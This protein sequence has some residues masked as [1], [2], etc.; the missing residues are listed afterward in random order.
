[1]FGG[2]EADHEQQDDGK[3]GSGNRWQWEQLKGGS[4]CV[5]ECESGRRKQQQR[6]HRT[7]RMHGNA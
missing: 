3:Q 6:H 7:I 4:V 5:A 2:E 1:M